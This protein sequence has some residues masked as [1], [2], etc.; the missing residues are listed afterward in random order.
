MAGFLKKIREF[1]RRVR[2]SDDREKKRW[3]VF[4]S[5][6]GMIAIVALWMAYLNITLPR[7]SAGE[8]GA[9]TK[10][11][12]TTPSFFKTLGTG[13]ESVWKSI[14]NNANGIGGNLENQWLN[15]MEQVKR[16]N[17]VNLEKPSN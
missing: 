14:E 11:I 9:A 10:E 7:S 12:T 3:V 15:L 1:L 17:D 6:I 2:R 8:A 5:A 16:T 13:W 4:F